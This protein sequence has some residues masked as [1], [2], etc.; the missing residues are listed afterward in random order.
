LT[1]SISELDELPESEAA[2]LLRSCCGSSHWVD[3]MVARRPYRSPDSL[4]LS[5]DEVWNSCSRSDWLEAFDHHPRIGG[6]RTEAQSERAAGWSRAEQAGVQ[7]ASAALQSELA[8]TNRT[9]EEKFGYIYIVCATGKS[10]EEMLS[11][12]RRR[13]END[14]LTELRT[15]AEE[16][17]KITRIRL[18]KLIGAQS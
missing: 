17:R 1:L 14:P 15:A 2:D 7:A 5:A 9:Y 16:Q 10:A 4:F 11:I 3:M 18:E 6:E 13:L 8:E 12:A